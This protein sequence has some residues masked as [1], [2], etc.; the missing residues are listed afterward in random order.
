MLK[1]INQHIIYFVWQLSAIGLS[2][3]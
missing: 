1:S 2:W 3:R